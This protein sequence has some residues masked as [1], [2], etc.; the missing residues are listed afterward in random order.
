MSDLLRQP[1]APLML[2]PLRLAEDTCLHCELLR[3]IDAGMRSGYRRVDNPHAAEMINAFFL[4][5]H[6]GG[7]KL[8][9]WEMRELTQL[10]RGQRTSID[11]RLLEVIFRK[12]DKCQ[13]VDSNWAGDIACLNRRNQ[14][15]EACGQT[16]ATCPKPTKQWGYQN[17]H[18]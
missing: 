16:V 13:V 6:Y 1:Y 11:S 3:K 5:A 8:K 9:Q 17:P 10:M 12:L 15:A 4:T 18:V 2:M 14:Q 7:W